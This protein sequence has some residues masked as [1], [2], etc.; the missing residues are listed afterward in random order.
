[1]L[2]VSILGFLI[3]LILMVMVIG[4]LMPIM[5]PM[6]V[7]DT[8]MTISMITAIELLASISRVTKS[9]N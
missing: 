2:R 5:V 8:N 4:P 9:L 3:T 6:S 7:K 1:M